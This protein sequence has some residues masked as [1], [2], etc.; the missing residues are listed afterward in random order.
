MRCG[1]RARRCCVRVMDWFH[2]A[3]CVGARVQSVAHS[4]GWRL[5]ARRY[6]R[7]TVCCVG[8]DEFRCALARVCAHASDNA[9]CR[10]RARA[11]VCARFGTGPETGTVRSCARGLR[12][13][14]V[15]ACGLYG[16]DLSG[17]RCTDASCGACGMFVR[18]VRMSVCAC[19]M[20]LCDNTSVYAVMT[21]MSDGLTG[22]IRRMRDARSLC[23]RARAYACSCSSVETGLLRYARMRAP[24]AP[25]RICM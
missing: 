22:L 2:V 13:L 9:V 5:R 3:L 16:T 4:D 14:V 25:P 24:D 1:T 21:D 8:P 7:G 11:P 18:D 12:R 23:A 17:P 20:R 19:V 10:T 6:A 15:C